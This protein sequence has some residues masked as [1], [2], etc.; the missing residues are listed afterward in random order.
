[1]GLKDAAV[2]M[3]LFCMAIFGIV[4]SG[5]TISTYMKTKKPQDS[6]FK[7]SI[8]VMVFSLL[9]LLGSGYF[10]YKSFSGEGVVAAEGAASNVQGVELLADIDASK[11][12][13]TGAVNAAKSNLQAQKNT[14]VSKL[15]RELASKIQNLNAHRTA[16]EEQAKIALVEKLQAGAN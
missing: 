6:G 15:E 2:P 8:A 5:I 4:Q 13:S 9:I 16:I 3:L 14:V 10:V 1:M 7:F 11:L 12:E